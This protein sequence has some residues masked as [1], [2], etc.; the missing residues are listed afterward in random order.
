MGRGMP[1]LYTDRYDQACLQGPGNCKEQDKGKWDK[2]QFLVLYVPTFWDYVTYLC[3]PHFAR[4]RLSYRGR[5]SRRLCKILTFPLP[6]PLLMLLS[7]I[8]E[9]IIS[10]FGRTFRVPHYFGVYWGITICNFMDSIWEVMNWVIAL[11]IQGPNKSVA[12]SMKRGPVKGRNHDAQLQTLFQSPQE[13][14]SFAF[15]FIICLFP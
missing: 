2:L 4:S 3:D 13:L 14:A 9:N 12:K 10:C 5:T 11:R 6:S 1:E 7:L 15:L 8:V